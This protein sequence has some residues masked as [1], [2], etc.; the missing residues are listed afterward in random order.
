[1]RRRA[2]GL[3]G[4]G[5]LAGGGPLACNPDE[6][7]HRIGWFSTMRHQR[8]IKPYAMPLNPVEGA[9][10]V[11]G[12]E[13]P[14]SAATADRLVNPR[15][16]TSESINR[17]QWVYATY[18][19]VCHGDAGKGDGPISALAGGP[20]PGIRSLVDDAAG[21]RTDGYI[22][23]VV[24]NAQALGRGIMPRYGDKVRGTDRWDV[25]NYVRTLQAQARSGTP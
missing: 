15:A 8:N 7:V 9:V 12:G 10:P 18:C 5:I 17:G 24:V 25:V 14:V 3:L 11:T 1:M 21:A 22:Y 13:L 16:K 19:L 2:L 20:F 23:G 4:L 6:V